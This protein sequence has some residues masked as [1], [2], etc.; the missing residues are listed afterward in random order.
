[1]SSSCHSSTHQKHEEAELYKVRSVQPEVSLPSN[2]FST[3]PRTNNCQVFNR[4]EPTGKPGLESFDRSP[5]RLHEGMTQSNLETKPTRRTLAQP[6][7][8]V[9][10]PSQRPALSCTECA[11]RKI[12]CDK[13]IPCTPCSKRGRQSICR[14]E[15]WI[16]SSSVN[17]GEHTQTSDDRVLNT[18]ND[19]RYE[20]NCLREQVQDL[21]SVRHRLRELEEIICHIHCDRQRLDKDG[22]VRFLSPPLGVS[23]GLT[24]S[25]TAASQFNGGNHTAS[26]TTSTIS[27]R[28]RN[29]LV[30]KH[31]T[32]EDAATTFEYLAL[33]GN[34]QG[35][36]ACD[37]MHGSKST[38][39]TSVRSSSANLSA[40]LTTENQNKDSLLSPLPPNALAKLKSSGESL[41][42]AQ[43]DAIID[44]ALDTLGWQHPVIH[45]TTFRSQ[46]STYWRNIQESNK[47]SQRKDIVLIVNQAW[48]ALYIALLSVGTHHM[49]PRFAERCNLTE[50]DLKTM[51]RL[52]FS[53]CVAALYRFNFLA[54]P[55]IEAVQ[56]VVVLGCSGYEIAPPNI[57][58]ALH[59]C[60]NSIAQTLAIH[61][62]SPDPPASNH[63]DQGQKIELSESSPKWS[64][65]EL[66]EREIAKRVWWALVTADWAAVPHHKS[67][68]ISPGHFTTP[69]PRNWPDKDF[70]EMNFSGPPMQNNHI[71]MVMQQIILSQVAEV[72]Q[73]FFSRLMSKPNELHEDTTF[74]ADSDIQRIVSELP[75]ILKEI[76]ENISPEEK[77]QLP[78]YVNRLRHFLKISCAH[79]R[80]V[81]H[82][83][84]LN[85]ITSLTACKSK[86]GQS[87]SGKI[88]KCNPSL[89]SD[90]QNRPTDPK[91]SFR[92]F[93]GSASNL[94][95]KS[96][97]ESKAICIKLSREITRE[98][99]ESTSQFEERPTWNTPY[100]AVGAMT[101]LSLDLLELSMHSSS[102]KMR[103]K[104][105]A[106]YEIDV[107]TTN[108][109]DRAKKHSKRCPNQN[110]MHS[111]EGS[112]DV[113]QVTNN[114]EDSSTWA[115]M[116][117][118]L[119][120]LTD[121]EIQ[122]TKE[123]RRRELEQGLMILER[124]SRWSPIA[125]RGVILVRNL[126]GQ[127]DF[128]NTVIDAEKT[129]NHLPTCYRPGIFATSANSLTTPITKIVA[130]Q[131]LRCTG[132][133]EPFSPQV[134]QGIDSRLININEGD[135]RVSPNNLSP[136]AHVPPI[137]PPN[138]NP[139]ESFQFNQVAPTDVFS[140]NTQP[141]HIGTSYQQVPTPELGAINQSHAQN[142]TFDMPPK[143]FEQK[144]DEQRRSNVHSNFTSPQPLPQSFKYTNQNP[145]LPESDF[146]Q[147]STSNLKPDYIS[148]I[149]TNSTNLNQIRNQSPLQFIKTPDQ[150]T[151]HAH[152]ID[153]SNHQ[154]SY[155]NSTNNTNSS[156]NLL[157][158]CS[159]PR[160]DETHQNENGFQT[161]NHHQDQ[162]RRVWQTNEEIG[163][164]YDY[165]ESLLNSSFGH[166][167][168]PIDFDGI[169]LPS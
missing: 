56:T 146:V 124:L 143:I 122:A 110:S 114:Q 14:Q 147:S 52:W 153:L 3:S 163:V 88:S 79:K 106:E 97:I 126:L 39:F 43:S 29:G 53:D 92:R 21:D 152:S 4:N 9:R 140:T 165:I 61:C 7:K 34:R 18:L 142:A 144:D 25:P 65:I 127:K 73:R 8:T 157:Q 45:F 101:L 168:A 17:A 117:T 35:S 160:S 166:Y 93:P 60:A 66:M 151:H 38:S 135:R 113:N 133:I 148:P 11:R 161:L 24:A 119:E 150:R 77:A 12:K 95:R 48:F 128:S 138:V 55:S 154:N 58:C 159:I 96:A 136:L 72:I 139:G 100:I 42:K 85:H 107:S 145:H 112:S 99:V 156:S 82:R 32:S 63:D 37:P 89:S 70:P 120:T 155:L 49:S 149:P 141:Y 169:F 20:V 15:L 41:S 27:E 80:L 10:K 164:P 54:N 108:S 33:G 26:P 40:A 111:F 81:I 67:W 98:I 59:A 123:V 158:P 91:A 76:R 87:T 47:V 90:P 162:T 94:N 28:R 23:E 46:V 62:I 57:L 6:N 103:N 125:E 137:L 68:C 5:H 116:S 19:L 130:R 16:P 22:D 132:Q 69:I 64:A 115:E 129:P 36:E 44:F 30:D 86:S 118:R 78:P 13:T 1:M 83:S 31:D 167:A 105:T 84:F 109:V 102:S 121:E 74:Q 51:P 50:D 131:D 71:S 134:K 2:S 75:P 104:R